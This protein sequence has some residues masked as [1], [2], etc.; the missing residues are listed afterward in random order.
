MISAF[1]NG[2]GTDFNKFHDGLPKTECAMHALPNVSSLH[3][4]GIEV[5]KVK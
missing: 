3:R 4:K 5:H 2:H 1:F